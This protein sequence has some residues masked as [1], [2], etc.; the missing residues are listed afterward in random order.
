M[1]GTSIVDLYLQPFDPSH[2]L[3]NKNE[4]LVFEGVFFYRD[5]E[6]IIYQCRY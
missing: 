6:E 4:R 1:G 3:Q 2:S 5:I